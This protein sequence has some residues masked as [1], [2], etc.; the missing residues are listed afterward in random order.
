M[1]NTATPCGDEY[2]E[3][4]DV[5]DGLAKNKSLS[6]KERE[7]AKYMA[8]LGRT[9]V[10]VYAMVNSG[11]CGT[12]AKILFREFDKCRTPPKKNCRIKAI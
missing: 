1:L 5:M 10:S 7:A 2:R 6:E 12:A 8:G 4:M 11:Q 3:I 9:L